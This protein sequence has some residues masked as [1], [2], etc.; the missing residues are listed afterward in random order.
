MTTTSAKIN[1][2]GL[3][4]LKQS[5]SF[6]YGLGASCA[7][8][9]SFLIWLG[10]K[11]HK[12]N[13]QLPADVTDVISYSRPNTLTIKAEDETILAQ[14]GDLPHETTA[15][16][17]I[18]PYLQHAF[19]AIEDSRF[20]EHQGIDL[21]GIARASMANLKSGKV[22]EG[23]STITQQLA[24]IAYLNQ[25]RSWERKVKEIVIA[26]RINQQLS[27]DEILATYLN[28]VYLGS[29]AYGVTDA[30]Y[31]YFSK[32]IEELTLAEMATLAGITPAPSLYSPLENPTAAKTR[33]DLVL[34][35]MLEQGYITETEAQQAIASPLIIQEG[36]LKR[37]GRQANYFVQYIQQE[38]P[39]YLSQAQIEKGGIIVNTTLNPEW[40]TIAEETVNSAVDKYGKWQKFSQ[41]ALV[42][43]NPKN[44]EIK[45]MVG[46]TDFENNQFN[47]VTQAQRQPGSTFKTFIYATAVAGGISPY[48]TYLDSPLVVDDYEPKNYKEQYQGTVPIYQALTS[49]LN[50]VAVK[51]LIDVGWNPI[52]QTAKKMG[53]QSELKPTYSLALGASEVNLLEL[54]SAYGTLANEGKYYTPHGIKTIVNTKGD[55]LYSANINPEI[56][57]NEESASITTWMLQKVVLSG[58]GIPAQIGRPV[59]GKTGT[60]DDSRDLWF[61]GYIPQ[62]VTGIW[63]GN[64]DNQETQSSS[65]ITAQMWRTFMLKATKDLPIEN[66]PQPPSKLVVSEKT[67]EFEPIKPKKMVESQ[68]IQASTSDSNPPPTRSYRRRSSSKRYRSTTSRNTYSAPVK[69][70]RK[71]SSKT[72]SSPEISKPASKTF[73]PTAP[74]L[75]KGSKS[76]D[77]D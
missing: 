54:T 32:S 2:L 26:Q 73:A 35:R 44:G 52:I 50:V 76:K 62:L 14:F 40:Q 17:T 16:S 3:K 53:I 19:I 49:S 56:A 21:Q 6:L 11:W 42:G 1:K 20:Y 36:N 67:I 71:S 29:G 75:N 77:G 51:N 72:I 45:T 59:A 12:M 64:D 31:R 22:V 15:L 18:P 69:T 34:N 5:R 25:D 27:K 37:Q 46:G 66:F 48:K 70:T 63:L 60:S 39:K 13:T 9:C 30:A 58:T 33:R 28:L 4:K 65:S 55:I 23:G 61:I 74:Q 8:G 24:R 57:L 7:L 68:I 38:L 43:I 41:G 10:I 47:R